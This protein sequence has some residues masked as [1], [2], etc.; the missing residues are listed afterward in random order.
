MTT[1]CKET[2]QAEK[3]KE[4]LKEQQPD[5]QEPESEAK[6]V[7][8]DDLAK[9]LKTMSNARAFEIEKTMNARID[10][11]EKTMNT[12]FYEMFTLLDS[13]TNLVCET[14]CDDNNN[15]PIHTDPPVTTGIVG[16]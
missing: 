7:T 1:P 6:P 2:I 13:V 12:R 10:E 9:V 16:N 3:E 15:N 11:M 5:Q 4:E 14:F 8:I